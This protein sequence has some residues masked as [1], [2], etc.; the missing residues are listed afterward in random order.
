MDQLYPNAAMAVYEFLTKRGI[1]VDYPQE[2]T[3]C[4]QPMANSG[5]SEEVVPLAKRFEKIFSEYDYIV[6]PSGSC[7]SMVRC[8]YDNYLDEDKYTPLK[9][10]VYE[11]CEFLVDVLDVKDIETYFPHKV[12]LHQ[13]CHGLRELRLGKSSERNIKPFSKVRQLLEQVEGL[14]LVDLNRTDECCGFGGTFAV[15]EEAISCQ[16]GKD[17]IEDHVQAGAQV[18]TGVDLSCLMHLDGLMKRNGENLPV[19]HIAEILNG[20]AQC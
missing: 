19:F 20:T 6:C 1:E 7:T 10:K 3:C 8:H 17:R 15:S 4:G 18:I 5:C 12:G 2:Q 9:K 14:E 13:S 16:M 11:F